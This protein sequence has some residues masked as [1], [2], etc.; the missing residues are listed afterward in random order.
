MRKSLLLL[1]LSALGLAAFGQ[2]SKLDKTRPLTWLGIDYSQLRFIG[3]ATQYKDAGEISNEKLSGTYFKAW[4]DLVLNEPDKYDLKKATGF[5]QVEMAPGVTEAVNDNSRNTDFFTEDPGQF[6]HLSEA[7]IQNLVRQYDY[8]SRSGTGLAF[9]VAGMDKGREAASIW[10]AFVD[11]DSKNLLAAKNYVSKA[12]GFGFRNYW[13]G[14]IHKT[15]KEM[16]G[17]F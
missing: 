3:T 6:Q 7:D 17:D 13:A 1:L 8:G 5:K 4:N 12:G 2:K 10:V 11:M 16:K 15:L 9:I 14:A